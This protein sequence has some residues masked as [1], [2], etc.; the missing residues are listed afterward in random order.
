MVHLAGEALHVGG[1]TGPVRLGLGEA[2]PELHSAAPHADDAS[3]PPVE[4]D[5]VTHRDGLFYSHHLLRSHTPRPEH[6]PDRA[7][8]LSGEVRRR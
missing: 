6:R 2:H 5:D 3:A 7:A 8:A 1:R 4:G